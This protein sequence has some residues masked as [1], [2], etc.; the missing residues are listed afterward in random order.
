[1][2]LVKNFHQDLRINTTWIINNGV[3]MKNLLFILPA[4]AI[5][6]ACSRPETPPPT[7]PVQPPT[8]ES[9]NSTPPP[10]AEKQ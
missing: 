9:S 3:P 10:T 1:M 6:S 7:T 2:V 5:L 8:V 4:L